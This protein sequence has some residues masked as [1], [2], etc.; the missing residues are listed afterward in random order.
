MIRANVPE[1]AA[2]FRD[3]RG[4]RV[5]TP[6]TSFSFEVARPAIAE[7]DA[8]NQRPIAN[9]LYPQGPQQPLRME[10]FRK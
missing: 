1:M 3:E 10:F 2:W 9:E 4:G 5:I 8:S 7:T 6:Q